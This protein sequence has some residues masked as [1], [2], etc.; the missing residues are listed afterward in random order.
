MK[1]LYMGFF[2]KKSFLASLLLKMKDAEE[3]KNYK[4]LEH[5]AS[6]K[7]FAPLAVPPKESYHFK[8]SGNAGDLIYSLPVVKALAMGQETHYHLNL[9]QRGNY[10]K[11]PHPLQGVML[12]EKMYRM[13]LPLLSVQDYISSCSVYNE[14]YID[15]DMDLI[16]SYP[17]PTSRGNISRWYCYLFA[18]TV[19][20]SK[21]WLTVQP[22]NSWNEHIVIARSQR[23]NAP[24]ISYNFLNKYKKKLFV[25]VEEEWREIK[26]MLPGIEFH[27]VNDFLQ[28]ASVIAGSKLF[29]GN[30]SF[31]FSL[32]EA[33][34]VPR[35]L[36]VYHLCPN[37]N[38][39]GEGANDFCYQPQFEKMVEKLYE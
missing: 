3:Y 19:D 15:Y 2:K 36:E 34:K 26:K 23:Y 27:P 38:V 32:A 10:G 5:L 4:Y 17:F 14:E 39:E 11:K 25:G 21:P 35:L 22:D 20:L 9:G 13:L 8:H 37:V 28:L 16:R 30:Q 24:A 12:N 33:M 31:P 6:I 18:I 29:I 1:V 7:I